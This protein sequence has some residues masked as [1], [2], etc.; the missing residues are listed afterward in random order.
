MI[1]LITDNFGLKLMSLC[2]AVLLWM[3]VLG[4][5]REVS[6][7]VAVEIQYRNTP[8]SLEPTS[9]LADTAYVEVRGPGS[10]L[11]AS[12]LSNAVVVIDLGSQTRPGERTYSILKDNVSLPAGIQ[13]LRSVPSQVRLRL[14]QR[15]MKAVPVVARY[16][17]ALGYRLLR[18]EISPSM[19]RIIGPESR[20][21][22]IDRVQ[23]DP[24]ELTDPPGETTFHVHAYTGDPRVRLEQ[25]DLV[26]QVKVATE[27]AR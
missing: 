9:D 2:V 10:R 18:Q 15:I 21:A 12:N 17:P 1:R 16:T 13:F 25:S 26:I 6:A 14:E 22:G 19:V 8:P 3:A 4:G 11:S 24:I 27:K 23:T 7:S 20:V 5:D